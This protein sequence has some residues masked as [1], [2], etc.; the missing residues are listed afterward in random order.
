MGFAGGRSP[1]LNPTEYT[2]LAVPPL[3]TVKIQIKQ[4]GFAIHSIHVFQESGR[5]GF[6][7]MVHSDNG[8]L[9]GLFSFSL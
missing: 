1:G 3:T 5:P 9:S 6:L 8:S 4:L 2:A 7:L